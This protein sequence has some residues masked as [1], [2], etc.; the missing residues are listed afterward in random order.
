M[1]CKCLRDGVDLLLTDIDPDDIK[2]LPHTTACKA[3]GYGK[4]AFDVL[5]HVSIYALFCPN[6][7]LLFPL[8]HAP[9]YQ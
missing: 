4:S 2:L 3:E 7:T 9:N 6:L 8:I 1:S 5:L